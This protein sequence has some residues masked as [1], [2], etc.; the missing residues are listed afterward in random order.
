[1]SS[2]YRK[3]WPWLLLIPVFILILIP[4]AEKFEGANVVEAFANWA[5]GRHHN[6]L[7]WAVRSLMML[8]FIY[9]SYRR[10]WHGI[11]V[12]LILIATNFFWFPMPAQP[13]PS[14]IEFLNAEKEWMMTGWDATKVLMSIS[15][16]MGLALLSAAF[17]KRSLLLGLLIIDGIFVLKTLFSVD[18]GESGWSLVPFLIMGLIVFNAVVLFAVR[19]A[20][21]YRQTHV[22]TP[23]THQ[24]A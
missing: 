18:L 15:G 8:P 2:S 10:S 1:M 24:A 11:I 19:F 21:S 4:G 12:S 22:L 7:S 23:S 9:F 14:T 6:T 20:R 16:A 5:W 13:D 17:W 3:A